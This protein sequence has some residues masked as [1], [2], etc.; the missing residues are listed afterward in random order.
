MATKQLWK[1]PYVQ[2][3][4]KL[5]LYSLKKKKK[6]LLVKIEGEIMAKIFSKILKKDYFIFFLSDM[7]CLEMYLLFKSANIWVPTLLGSIEKRE[8]LSN[9]CNTFPTHEDH[10]VCFKRML[11]LQSPLQHSLRNVKFW[12]NCMLCE[13]NIF[14]LEGF[15][16]KVYFK[17]CFE[18]QQ[19]CD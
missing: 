14:L 4:L 11:I 9:I 10:I 1:F 18:V 7:V 19:D 3:R 17:V 15:I 13:S 12:E 8:Q 5:F 6:E 2:I 16:E